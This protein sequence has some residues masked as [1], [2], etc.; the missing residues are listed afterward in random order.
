LERTV[1]NELERI[2]VSREILYSFLARVFLVEVDNEF[3]TTII[4][5]QPTIE[6]LASKQDGTELKK[7]SMSLTEF[8]RRAA[9]LPAGGRTK[10]LTDL[11]AEYASLFLAAGKLGD[12]RIVFPCE[13]AYFTTPPRNFGDPYH[14]VIDAFKSVGYEKPRNFLDPEDHIATELDFM[15]H[16]SRQVRISIQEEK[17][18]YA[19]RY[20]K[21]QR[22]FLRDHLLRWV[23]K[24]CSAILQVAQNEFYQS[25]ATIT[26][27][28]VMMDEHIIDQMVKILSKRKDDT[29]Q[30]TASF[31]LDGSTVDSREILRR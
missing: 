27:G 1:A 7:T 13:S 2:N 18:D 8:G 9:G 4:A 12:R 15:A 26:N 24:L 31:S 16:M 10:L 30:A 14:E 5:I 22:E 20:L 23:G 25:I 21:L 3:I 6:S 11:A 17:Y 28:F 29:S 19:I